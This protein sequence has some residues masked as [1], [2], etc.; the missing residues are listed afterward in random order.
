[1]HFTSVYCFAVFSTI[2]SWWFFTIWF[3]S[4][5]C[6]GLHLWLS[7][8]ESTYNLGE[9]QILFLG[10]ED[11]LVKDKATHCSFHACLEKSHGQRKLVGCGLQSMDLQRVGR[12]L[13]TKQQQQLWDKGLY[14]PAGEISVWRCPQGHKAK[15]SKYWVFFLVCFIAS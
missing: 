12:D 9:T 5:N 10:G 14:A 1:M 8:K 3:V 13:A 7:G 2:I 6:E 11:L 15:A 4:R